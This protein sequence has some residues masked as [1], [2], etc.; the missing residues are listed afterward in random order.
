MRSRL[1]SLAIAAL[2]I[3]AGAFAVSAASA[4]WG[5]DPAVRKWPS[6]P[7]QTTCG[8][9]TF[10]PAEAF[11][12]PTEAELGSSPAEI[13]LRES[14]AKK[15]LPWVQAHDWRLL[16][17]G[18]SIAEFAHGM[19]SAE[20]EWLQLDDSNGRWKLNSYSSDCDP[21]SILSEGPVV[22]WWLVPWKK[23]HRAANRVRVSLEGGPCDGGR[24]ENPHAHP[25]FEPL[26]D[27]MLMTIWLDPLPAEGYT[28]PAL[29]EP[30]LIVK[31]PRRIRLGRLYDGSTYP[32]LSAWQTR[33][34]F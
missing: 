3:A 28:C 20:V 26:G 23:H 34:R 21:E 30:P 29:I 5:A 27:K 17:E 2:C 14:L 1:G 6:W 24:A 8:G 16:V 15:E 22:S 13:A 25:I 18:G 32:P 33:H 12:G 7:Y 10:S 9:L 11:S 19:L 4:N 31:L